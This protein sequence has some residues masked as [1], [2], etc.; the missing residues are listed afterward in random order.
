MSL[1]RELTVAA[2]L[3]IGLQHLCAASALAADAIS[4]WQSTHDVDHP[5]VGTVWSSDGK[6]ASRAGLERSVVSS[7]FLLLGEIHDNPDHH[8]LQAELLAAMT[9]AG[10]KPAL[11]FEMIPARFQ[12]VLDAFVA[13]APASTTG[14]GPAVD[15]ESRGWPKWSIYQPIADAAL[16][17]GLPMVAGDLDRGTIR[18]IGKR[19]RAALPPDEQERLSLIGELPEKLN[20]EIRE[21]LRRSHCDL[22]PDPAI[23]PMLLVQRARD[24]ALA[25]AMLSADDAGADGVVLIAGAGHTRRDFA[26][27]S[28]LATRKPG[29]QIL[30]VALA[31]VDPELKSPAQY[32]RLN[33]YDFT[34]FTP[35]AD[36]TDHCAEL[37][38]QMK[39][40]P[41]TK[42][43]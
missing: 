27:P 22:L 10:R 19:G 31:E 37:A 24:G 34:I 12:N 2:G 33:L 17:A 39:G 9:A 1:H 7:D 13:A 32:G 28:I 25:A 23:E 15:W 18:K 36:L 43:E 14:L 35:R 5:L 38:E 11:V 3:L 16:A 8:R 26:V 42:A 4:D 21:V 40:K 6:P 20:A 41:Q 30:S 29:A